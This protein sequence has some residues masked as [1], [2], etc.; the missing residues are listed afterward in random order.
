MLP[1]ASKCIISS[2]SLS[3]NTD[4]VEMGTLLVLV[5]WHT[6]LSRRKTKKMKKKKGGEK[7][8]E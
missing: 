5:N 6:G 7:I 4:L 3:R 2:W 8:E 1:I